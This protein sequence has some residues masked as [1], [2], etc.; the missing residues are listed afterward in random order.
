M[1]IFDLNTRSTMSTGNAV[2]NNGIAGKVEDVKVEVSKR[3]ADEPDNYPAYKVVFT[4]KNG[5]Q[6]NQGFYEFVMNE[7]K[8]AE[9]NTKA[10]GWLVDR[11]LS[12]AQAVV[13][14]GF[15]YPE[16]AETGN[17]VEDTNKA[18]GTIFNIVK[19]NENNS[20]VNIFAT[21]G[22]KQKPSKYLNL[23]YFNFVEKAG[24]TGFS[25]LIEKGDDCME[26][27]TED[28]P[29]QEFGGVQGDSVKAEKP[30]W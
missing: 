20:L 4:D 28:Q 22:T 17:L 6:I 21:Y 29:K 11:A 26:R 13:P 10:S 23:R 24:T 15:V 25:R 5:S 2:F 7:M 14:E 12:I 1:S 30:S 27:I 9:D 18:L 3:R 19:E 8:S 16:I